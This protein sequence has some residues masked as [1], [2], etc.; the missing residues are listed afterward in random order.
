M[1]KISIIVPIYNAEKTLEKCIESILKQTF[2]NFELILVNDGSTDK[3]LVICNRYSNKDKRI[4]IIDKKNEG[5]IPTRKRGIKESK[6]EYVTFID[7]DDWIRKD[8][9]EI[10]NLE[11]NK[12]NPDVIVFNYYRV[13]NNFR[14]IKRKNKS[15]YFEKEKKVYENDE[16]K[17][18]LITAYFHGHPFPANLWGKIYRREYLDIE[19]KYI[20]HIKFLGED[21]YMN[22]EILLNAKKVSLIN[23][24]LYFYRTGGY[25]SKYMPYFF[26][27]ITEGYNS[28][29]K[30]IDEYGY[31]T[32][33]IDGISIMLLNTLRSCIYNLFLGNLS[34]KEILNKINQ[35]INSKQI[36]DS[37]ENKGAISY[38]AKFDAEYLKA[39][40]RKDIKFLY[41][42]QLK[43][44]KKNKYKRVVQKIL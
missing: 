11:I 5:A 35:Y 21:L 33:H 27:D 2:K 37:K 24:Y 34:E 9:L 16:I 10:I 39:L 38:F 26:N 6:S 25:T 12:N 15:F 8:T 32:E 30:V 42:T 23:E 18:E 4:R 31:G 1:S 7:A 29:K 41:Q 20:K 43:E 22:M 19:D 14:I 40:N 13:F 28:Q 17:D 36:I 3:S 44:F